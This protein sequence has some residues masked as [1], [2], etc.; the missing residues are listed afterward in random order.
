[1]NTL[2]TIGVLAHP[3]RPGTAP[4][5]EKVA[6]SLRAKGKSVWVRTAWNAQSVQPLVEESD[7]IVAIGGDGAMLRTARLCAPFGVPIFG[8]NAGRL[9][10]LT[11]AAPDTWEEAEKR[12]LEGDYWIENRMM[13]RCDIWNAQTSTC[14]SVEDALNDIVIGR[15]AIARSVYLEAY[16]NDI[17]TT[18]YNADAVIVATPTGSTAYALAVGGPLLPPQLKNILI[19]PVAPHLSMDRSIVISSSDR[20][21]ISV[22]PRSFDPEVVVTIDGELVG[23][24]TVDDYVVISASERFSSFVRIREDGYFFRSILDRLEPRLASQIRSVDDLD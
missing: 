6:A 3:Y 24:L 13:L 9:G 11:E 5:A 20:V 18:T 4:L 1:M 16:I 17:W 14:E 12:L 22:A 23:S 19:A 7:L 15:G 2:K 8:I 10:F 21:R